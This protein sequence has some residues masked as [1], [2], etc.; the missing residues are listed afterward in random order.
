MLQAE[1]IGTRL[2]F[3]IPDWGCKLPYVHTWSWERCSVVQFIARCFCSWM[4]CASS[5]CPAA[6]W[7][8]W[9]SKL[10]AT[11][12]TVDYWYGTGVSWYKYKQPWNCS[13]LHH[14][15]YPSA[16]A[17]RD[18]IQCLLLSP[19]CCTPRARANNASQKGKSQLAT[20]PTSLDFRTDS[21]WK[22]K[23][24]PQRRFKVSTYQRT[25]LNI[26]G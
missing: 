3:Q 5:C 22:S 17:R 23:R 24:G 4:L 20:N 7:S 14:F 6:Y 10:E 9:I 12:E 25:I 16:G 26:I 11:F 18:Q 15:P 1:D 8:I 2:V 13:C 19:C 21:S